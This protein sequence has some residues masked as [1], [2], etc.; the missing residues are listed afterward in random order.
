MVRTAKEPAK[1]NTVSKA[2]AKEPQEA[3]EAELVG[4]EGERYARPLRPR[5][6]GL[7]INAPEYSETPTES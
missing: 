7:A 4:R 3:Q 1:K 6:E 2:Q 5:R